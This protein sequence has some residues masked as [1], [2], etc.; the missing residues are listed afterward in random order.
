MKYV[1]TLDFIKG[2]LDFIKGTL[3]WTKTINISQTKV[4]SLA[5][6]HDLYQSIRLITSIHIDLFI[7][8]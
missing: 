4:A 8:I 5:S 3:E 7:Q 2:K 6:L 1:G